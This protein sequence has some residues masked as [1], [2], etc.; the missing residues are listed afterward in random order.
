MEKVVFDEITL[1]RQTGNSNNQVDSQMRSLVLS[2]L[3]FHDDNI[4]R[5]QQHALSGEPCSQRPDVL[6]S[7]V[8]V[9]TFRW[10]AN[11]ERLR[12]HTESPG[13]AVKQK[14]DL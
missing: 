1:F 13:P 7:P 3:I 8:L 9:C 4:Y 12:W 14:P 5:G 6:K 2:L 10:H 11:T